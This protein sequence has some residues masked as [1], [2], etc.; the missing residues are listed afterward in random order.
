MG[1]A[2][3]DN[4]ASSLN[5]AWTGWGWDAKMA[6]FD[7]SGSLEVVQ[8]DGFIKGTISRWAWL[9][10]LAMSNDLM[11]RNPAMWPKAEPGDDIAGNDTLAFWVRQGKTLRQP[12]RRAGPRRADPDPGRR[13]GRHQRRRRCRTSP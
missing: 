9:Q 12:Q 10:E 6:D 4:K 11:L 1:V 8:A 5:M 13:G 2:P 3:Y 7:N